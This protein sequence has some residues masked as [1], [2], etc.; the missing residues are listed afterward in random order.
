[1]SVI[2]Q[3]REAE[4]VM[5]QAA[6][7]IERL[8]AENNRLREALDEIRDEVIDDIDLDMNDRPNQAARIVNIIDRAL[9][10]IP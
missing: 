3:M 7:E 9:G 6:R 2:D 4:T 5:A 10:R 8:R 1:M